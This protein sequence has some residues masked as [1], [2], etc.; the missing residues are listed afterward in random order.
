MS[1]ANFLRRRCRHR[2]RHRRR[3]SH[4]RQHRQRNLSMCVRCAPMSP[5]P[6]TASSSISRPTTVITSW[7]W[8]PRSSISWP[9]NASVAVSLVTLLLPYSSMIASSYHFMYEL[10]LLNLLNSTSQTTN[11]LCLETRVVGS[12]S[13]NVL[14]YLK[15]YVMLT[16]TNTT[17]G[18]TCK[19]FLWWIDRILKLGFGHS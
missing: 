2:Q 8:E 15:K 1:I 4:Q 16:N 13:P 3:R 17:N 11:P 18:C 19:G 6:M 10:I 9:L 5:R 14:F 12:G 7:G